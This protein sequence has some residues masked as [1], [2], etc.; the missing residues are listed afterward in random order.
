L[1]RDGNEKQ[2]KAVRLASSVSKTKNCD[3][4]AVTSRL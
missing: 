3:H 2:T 4:A 1:V